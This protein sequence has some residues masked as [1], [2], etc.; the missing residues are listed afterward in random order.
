MRVQWCGEARSVNQNTNSGRPCEQRWSGPAVK[1]PERD[2]GRLSPSPPLRLF[3][4][5]R[6]ADIKCFIQSCDVKMCHCVIR[7]PVKD[8]G[9]G[10]FV[11]DTL[12]VK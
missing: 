10:Q 1:G 9:E 12:V 3:S 5:G 4:G 11:W 2:S 7:W 8:G 6:S